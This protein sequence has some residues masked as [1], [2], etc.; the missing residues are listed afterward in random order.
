MTSIVFYFQ[1]HQ[2]FR[3]RHYTFFEIGKSRAYFN[4]T[5]NA[6][7][8]RRVAAKCYLPM[9]ALILDLI[10]RHEGKFRCAYSISGT[11]LTQFEQWSPETLQSFQALAATGGV[12]ILGETSHHSLAFLADAGEFDA[13]VLA[14]RDRIE[15]LFGLQPT[16]F[17]NTELVVDNEIARR[18]ENLGFTGILGEGADHILG[19]RSTNRVYRPETCEKLKILLRAYRLSDDIAFRFSN[20][21][22]PE[23]PLS[24]DRFADWVRDLP[25]E[26]PYAGLFM[27]YETFGE[28]QWDETGI[29]DFMRHLPGAILNAGLDFATPA[30]VIEREDPI[31]RLDIPQPVSWADAERDLTAWL[32]N[33]MQ[34]AAHE[35]LYALLPMARAAAAA[36][37]PDLYE[38]W[39]RLSTSDHVYYMCTK[40]FSDGDVHKYFSPYDTPHDAFISFMNVIDGLRR[41]MAAVVN[42]PAAAA[43]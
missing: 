9:N 30:E 25:S 27:D 5:E 19:W 21:D 16:T 7:I 26:D 6:R 2:P 35:A 34:V 41:E 11:A 17:R 32:G 15:A 36:G 14:H 12:E 40:W 37:R 20:R 1:V 28:H 3:L 4:D 10:E 39:R 38:T 24:A 23:W 31:A 18:V 43:E 33:Q 22:W 29:F 42:A 8:V 13:Q